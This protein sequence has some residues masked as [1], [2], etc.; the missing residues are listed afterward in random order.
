MI[1]GPV[2]QLDL[3]RLLSNDSAS[4]SVA[5]QQQIGLFC[6]QVQAQNDGRQWVFSQGM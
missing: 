1:P 4:D 3:K 5:K 6:A 2:E